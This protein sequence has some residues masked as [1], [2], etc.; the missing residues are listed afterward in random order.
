MDLATTNLPD[1][2]RNAQI[3]WLK[4]A[5]SF[6]MVMRRSGLVRN[7]SIPDTTGNTREFSEIDLEGLADDKGEREQAQYAKVQ[8]GYTKVGTLYRVAKAVPISY[9]MRS[10]GKYP[11]IISKLTNLVPT[12][13]KRMELD[14]QHRLTFSTDSSYEN[15]NGNTIDTTVGDGYPLAY[16]AHTVRGSAVTFRNRLANNP[17]FSRGSLEAMEKMRVENHIN[18][19]GEKVPV[20]DDII[21]T[22]DNPNTVNT[23]RELLRS[24]ASVDSGANAGVNNPYMSKY[25]HVVLPYVATDNMMNVDSTKANYWGL[26]SSM[27]SSFYLGVNEEPHVSDIEKDARTDEW[28]FNARGGWMIV[29]PSAN[30]FSI[31]TGDGVA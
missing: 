13:M 10:Y 2:I 15:K 21:W 31:S 12:V 29:I 28:L 4:G 11:E 26:A 5:D 18:Q 30:W 9:E 14:L 7:V 20:T 6:Q 19:L 24:T 3:L 16:T 23:V 22:T 1:F 27:E 25:R 8:Q 17:I